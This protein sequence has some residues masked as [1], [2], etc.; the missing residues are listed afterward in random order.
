MKGNAT[1]LPEPQETRNLARAGRRG[2]TE[3]AHVNPQESMLLKVLGGA[4]TSNPSS[5]LPEFYESGSGPGGND[6]SGDNA[7]DTAGPSQSE[8]TGGTSQ[9][10]FESFLE[11]IGI[12]TSWESAFGK[13]DP[14]TQTGLQ[15]VISLGTPTAFGL[16][17][18]ALYEGTKAL[19]EYVGQ[20]LNDYFGGQYSKTGEGLNASEV[21]TS[22]MDLS[23]PESKDT[24]AS[25]SNNALLDAIR[26]VQSGASSP[27]SWPGVN[28]W[29]YTPGTNPTAPSASRLQFQNALSRINDPSWLRT[30]VGFGSGNELLDSIFAPYEQGAKDYLGRAQKRGMLDVPSYNAAVEVLGQQ[31]ATGRDQLS[32]QLNE[33]GDTL[34]QPLRSRAAEL[35]GEIASGKFD[36]TP[37]SDAF[38]NELFGGAIGGVKSRAG[39]IG[40]AAEN[41]FAP[42]TALYSGLEK[43]GDVRGSPLYSAIASTRSNRYNPLSSSRGVGTKGVF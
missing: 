13:I 11:S 6:Y 23:G 29:R 5:G 32:R 36:A 7:R 28:D 41:P 12:P 9:S 3:L 33:Q 17:S 30:N 4:G 40:N 26:G 31:G 2:D 37:F 38:V 42:S 14:R 8:P 39:E 22:A 18:R 25:G 15:N 21:P 35:Q 34:L 1:G 16:G 24:S 20:P 43:G 19:G 27:Y 10:G